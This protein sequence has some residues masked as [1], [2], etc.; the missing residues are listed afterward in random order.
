MKGRVPPPMDW[1]VPRPPVHAPLINIDIKEPW[2]SHNGQKAK[3]H[4][5][6]RQWSS[7]LCLT[8]LSQSPVQW[9]SLEQ[10]WPALKALVYPA[11]GLVLGRPPL[12]SF[13]PHSSWNSS[14]PAGIGFTIST[15][16]SNSPPS[17]Q[18]FLLP[19]PSG[20]NRFHSVDWWDE[21]R[22]SQDSPPYSNKAQIFLSFHTQNNI[23][24][25]L[26]DDEALCP[27]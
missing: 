25:S 7:F 11:S 9:Q 3:G 2:G 12:L 4:F 23:P 10:I 22:A 16:S 5:P 27:S 19:P 15:K 8:F 24:S 1:L 26:R 20:T 17:R 13:F 21:C 18:L 14:V 6:V